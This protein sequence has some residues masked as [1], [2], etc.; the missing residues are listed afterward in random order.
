M[1]CSADFPNPSQYGSRN[2]GTLPDLLQGF[3]DKK[4]NMRLPSNYVLECIVKCI[5][6]DAVNSAGECHIPLTSFE[7]KLGSFAV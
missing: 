5:R 1:Q 2:A 4:T 7:A 3:L 6:N